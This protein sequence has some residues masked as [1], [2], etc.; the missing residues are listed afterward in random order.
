MID[1]LCMGHSAYDIHFYLDE[2]PE[3]DRKYITKKGTDCGGGPAANA[4]Y[5]LSKWR[6]NAGYGGIVGMDIFGRAVREELEAAETDLTFLQVRQ[7]FATPRSGVIINSRTGTRTLINMR[8]ENPDAPIFIDQVWESVSPQVLLADG[9]YFGLAL[10]A[11]KRFPDAP[12][13]LDG[14]SLHEGTETLA[15]KADYLIVSEAF[16]CS[17]TGV[18]SLES[19]DDLLK[20]AE[21]VGELNGRYAAV[22]LGGRGV[23]YSSPEGKGFVPPFPVKAVDTTGAGDIFH[24]AFAYCIFWGMDFLESLEFS[25]LTASMSAVKNGG[26]TSI[27]E[28]DDVLDEYERLG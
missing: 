21:S 19:E 10:E 24:G 14:G 25:S 22:T 27:P 6:L 8:D 5:L 13:I 9:H 20:A 4:A 26:R 23:V 12:F 18:K 1:I 3:E 2:Y 16:A 28:L 11:I 17:L 15:P 7:N